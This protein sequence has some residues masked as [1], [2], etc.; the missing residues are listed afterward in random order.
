MYKEH[1]VAATASSVP[2]DGKGKWQCLLK[3]VTET[4]PLISF[5]NSSL[6]IGFIW[7]IRHLFLKKF[8]CRGKKGWHNTELF[9]FCISRSGCITYKV[10]WLTLSEVR[11]RPQYHSHCCLLLI[12]V[13]WNT[14]CDYSKDGHRAPKTMWFSLSSQPPTQMS[15]PFHKNISL[16]RICANGERKKPSLTDV[17]SSDSKTGHWSE[18]LPGCIHCERW[19]ECCSLM[20]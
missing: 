1:P 9:H 5:E 15:R 6:S 16:F 13:L 12:H 19:H 20:R 3:W 2:D 11:R 18:K 7:C 17:Q 4:L 8:K 10:C 14:D